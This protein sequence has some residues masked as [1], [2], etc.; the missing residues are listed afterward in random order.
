MPHDANGNVINKGD[1][2]MVP[3]VVTDVQPG[4]EYCNCTLLTAYPMYPSERKDTIVVNT[5]QVV[6]EPPNPPSGPA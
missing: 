2:V 1:R 4:A 6:L 3:C 5:R